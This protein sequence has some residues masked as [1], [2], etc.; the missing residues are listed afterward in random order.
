MHE[1]NPQAVA[2]VLANYLDQVTTILPTSE[3]DHKW[4]MRVYREHRDKRVCRSEFV[5]VSDSTLFLIAESPHGQV[6]PRPRSMLYFWNNY[7]WPL[8][9]LT[10][11]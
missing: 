5:V 8:Y 7:L 11:Y 4:A 9:T 3:I 6:D 2:K 10:L 1:S